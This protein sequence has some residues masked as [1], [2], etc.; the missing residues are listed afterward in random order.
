VKLN[1]L[2]D[3]DLET[4]PLKIMTTSKIGSGDR[5][6]IA[7]LS[8]KGGSAGEIIV[9]L[10]DPPKFVIRD[11]RPRTLSNSDIPDKR[12]NTWAFTENSTALS[13]KCNDV[14]VV[15]FALTQPNCKAVWKRDT[16]QMKFLEQATAS[17]VYESLVK[18]TS[19]D[20]GM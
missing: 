3:H 10:S 2:I 7:F 8:E 6:S 19:E 16:T 15:E 12:N 13:I 4:T 14:M 1:V 5:I 18:D 11:C 9:S 20:E 17:D